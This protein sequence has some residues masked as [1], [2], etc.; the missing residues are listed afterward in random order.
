MKKRLRNAQVAVVFMF[1]R[2]VLQ[3]PIDS[4]ID[5]EEKKDI[6]KDLGV[7]ISY[8]DADSEAYTDM[9]M[10]D[11]LKKFLTAHETVDEKQEQIARDFG[12]KIGEIRQLEISVPKRVMI[13][14]S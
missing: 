13:P 14:T 11:R 3:V 12:L 7:D 1:C 8:L 4:M 9:L 10:Q 6:L 5:E 2:Q